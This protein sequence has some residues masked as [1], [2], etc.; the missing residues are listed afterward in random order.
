VGTHRAMAQAA[1]YLVGLVAFL[2]LYVLLRRRA[3]AQ[4]GDVVP[5][6][7]G[8]LAAIVGCAAVAVVIGAVTR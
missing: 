6:K 4:T 7:W 2:G 1:V 3:Q 5:V 8:W